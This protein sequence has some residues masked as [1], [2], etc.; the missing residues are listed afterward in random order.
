MFFF[1]AA[2]LLER[3]VL[4]QQQQS[5]IIVW[6]REKEDKQPHQNH[7]AKHNQQNFVHSLLLCSLLSALR[8]V[9][10]VGFMRV[11]TNE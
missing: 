3:R 1:E 11:L 10:V 8:K 5:Q 6:R 4:T 2:H 7:Q 9:N